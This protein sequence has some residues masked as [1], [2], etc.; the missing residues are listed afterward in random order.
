M[1]AHERRALPEAW[2]WRGLRDVA[3]FIYGY[4]FDSSKFNNEGCGIPLIRIRRKGN[5][6]IPQAFCSF[7]A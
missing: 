7:Q 4:P 1:D 6:E 3:Q 2:E 5:K